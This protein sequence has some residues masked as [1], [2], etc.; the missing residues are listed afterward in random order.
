MV[1]ISGPSRTW[2]PQT[3]EIKLSECCFF[4]HS[5]NFFLEYSCQHARHSL[6]KPFYRLDFKTAARELCEKALPHGLPIAVFAHCTFF[7]CLLAG[8]IST[9]VRMLLKALNAA[10]VMC[11]RLAQ[12][13]RENTICNP[14]SR[15]E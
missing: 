14:T 4:L 8:C 3:V 9:G 5:L 13:S 1:V 10:S 6:L 7:S 2:L 11:E 12:H 15:A